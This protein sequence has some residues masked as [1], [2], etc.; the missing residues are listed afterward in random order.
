MNVRKPV[1]YSTMYRELAAILARNLPQ[2]DEIYA[3]GKVISQRPEKGAAVA[4]A[5]FLQAK[6]PDRTGFSPR[7]VRRMRVFYKTYEN[8]QTLLRLAMKI[9]WTLNVVIME[10][11]LT[12]DARKW[13]LE[14]ARVQKWSKKELLEILS[15]G[16][17]PG[18]E[19]DQENSSLRFSESC[20]IINQKMKEQ[21]L[22]H[23]AIT[24]SKA[25]QV[26]TFRSSFWKRPRNWL[27]LLLTEICWTAYWFI[28][29]IWR[30]HPA[31]IRRCLGRES[32]PVSVQCCW[33]SGLRIPY[34]KEV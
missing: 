28:W 8:D 15:S 20:G 25:M 12:R 1:D 16:Y 18:T 31:E 23:L 33:S 21:P 24:L 6:F 29:S 2:M 26:R 17:E 5:E 11:E 30:A 10:S 22:S 7:N 27:D 3:I 13:Y 19:A 34:L 14:Q 9:G 32:T 4:A